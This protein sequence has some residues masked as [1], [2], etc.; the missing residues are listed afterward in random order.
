MQSLLSRKITRESGIHLTSL[1]SRE[2]ATILHHGRV[3]HFL[4][5]ETPTRH[6]VQLLISYQKRYLSGHSSSLPVLLHRLSERV[7]KK[8]ERTKER[9][10]DEED[11]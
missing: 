1:I 2:T 11:E 10:T 8:R 5:K 7:E 3:E 9:K 6:V 4:L